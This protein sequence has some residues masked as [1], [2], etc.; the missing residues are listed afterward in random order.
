MFVYRNSKASEDATTATVTAI[1]KPLKLVTKVPEA[2][3]A[4]SVEFPVVTL[5]AVLFELVP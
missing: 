4:A 1:G 5:S 2:V 3:F